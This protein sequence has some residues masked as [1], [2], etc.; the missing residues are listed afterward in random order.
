MK[1]L[2]RVDSATCY[3][4]DGSC[5]VHD[6]AVHRHGDLGQNYHDAHN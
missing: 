3:A 1:G 4:E 2:D 5:A 6:G